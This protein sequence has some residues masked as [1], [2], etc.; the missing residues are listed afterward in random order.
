MR[1]DMHPRALR[2]GIP[3]ALWLLLS[4][5]RGQAEPSPWLIDANAGVPRLKSGDFRVAGDATL[6]YATPK[7][8]VV[9]NG[10]ISYFDVE[11]GV[12]RSDFLRTGGGGEAWLLTGSASDS[13]NFELRG[14]GGG[15][16]Y[17]SQ[18]ILT[19]A[20]AN[21]EEDSVFGRGSLLVGLKAR[22]GDRFRAELLLGGGGQFEWYIR[23]DTP[24][25][26]G[27]SV[28]F[29]QDEQQT[30]SFRGEGRLAL[31]WRFVP[32]TLGMRLKASGQTFSLTRTAEGLQVKSGTGGGTVAQTIETFEFRQTEFS[33]R[34]FLDIEAASFGGI[35]PG[36]FGG[37]D[38]LSISGTAGSTSSFIPLGGVGLFKDID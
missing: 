12:Q 23:E 11:S 16:L 36:A 7:F 18:A 10:F 27:G 34:L 33:T 37:F 32:D 26:T 28:S 30:L 3:C 15:Y 13:F 1:G 31:R 2:V 5:A 14:S 35:T 24:N 25:S 38:A 22:S 17:S 6:G 21:L 4:P 20:S 29:S 19:G 9:G 8:G